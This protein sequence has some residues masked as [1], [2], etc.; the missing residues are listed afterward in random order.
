MFRLKYMIDIIRRH[1]KLKCRVKQLESDNK[2]LFEAV[3]NIEAALA[4]QVTYQEDPN[5]PNSGQYNPPKN[6][7]I[8]FNKQQL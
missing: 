1:E 6:T 4:G 8:G 5:N 7:V 2:I 3:G